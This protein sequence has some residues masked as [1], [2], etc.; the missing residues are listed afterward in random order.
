MVGMIVDGVEDGGRRI[1]AQEET[2]CEV[3]YG[4]LYTIGAS[5]CL[6]MVLNSPNGSSP[7]SI[8]EKGLELRSQSDKCRD[9]PQSHAAAASTHDEMQLLLAFRDVQTSL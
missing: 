5:C 2:L 4:C 8:A 9:C 7:L 1:L 3:T 6:S